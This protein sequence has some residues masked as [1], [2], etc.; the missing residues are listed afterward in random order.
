MARGR[1]K[2]SKLVEGKIIEA[3]NDILPNTIT[4]GLGEGLQIDEE[5]SEGFSQVNPEEVKSIESVSDF[6]GIDWDFTIYDQIE[7]FQSDKSYELT[8]YRPIDETHGLDFNPSWFTEVRDIKES[9]GYYTQYRPGTKA[10]RDFWS[11]QYRRCRDGYESHGY[12]IT[13]DNYFFLNFYR[14]KD[15]TNV[16]VASSGR[17]TSFPQFFSK[18]Y[19]YFHYI[20]LCTHTKHDVCALKAR[21][22]G[23]S[24]IAASLAV[25]MYT[26]VREAHVICTAYSTDKL[27]PLLRKCW[28][29]LEY[30]NVD[31]EDGMRHVRQ[32]YNNDMHK[33]ASKLNK[34]REEY[35]WKSD[36]LGIVADNPN[37]LRGERVDLLLFEEAGSNPVLLKTYIQSNA[38]VEI[39]G[40]KF[41]TR[42]IWG[43]GGDAGA[44]LAGLSKVFYNPKGYNVLPFKHNYSKTG[45][46][47]ETSYFIPAFTFVAGEGYID[48]R[49]VTDTKKAKEYYNNKKNALAENPKEYI[50]FCAEYCFTPEDALALEG[51]NLFNREILANQKAQIELHKAGPRPVRGYLEYKFKN[52]EHTEEAKDG[53]KFIPNNNSK[54]QILEHPIRSDNNEAI[55]NLYVAGIDGIDLGAKETSEATKDPSDFCIIIFRRMKGE[56]PP[57]PVAFYKDRPGDVREAYRIALKLLEYYNCKALLEFSKIGFKNFLVDKRI[58]YKWLMRRTKATLDSPDAVSRQYGVPANEKVI[59]HQLELLAS[60]IQ[61]FGDNIWFI[62][63]INELL[64]YS[65][66]NKRKFD[67][68]AAM[69]MC[70]LADEELIG[71]IPR[72]DEIVSAKWR[73]VGWYVDEKGYKR[74]GI[75]QHQQIETKVNMN[76]Y[77]QSR[78]RSSRPIYY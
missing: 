58:E 65:Y 2:G 59:Q 67:A 47:V 53:F 27:T 68:V 51:D 3:V 9:T 64:E 44:A 5:A 36:I 11:E 55:R 43:T 77:D 8:K 63:I 61:D 33:K 49:G 32:K 12:R 35:G 1:K 29:Q 37:K 57:M 17:Q 14:L 46:L 26:V 7:Y 60:Y 21:G 56:S 42:L 52:N 6:S 39:L 16:K 22:V 45:E 50:M 76:F 30:L 4:V 19:E 70:M 20:D 62:E 13:G 41:G 23:F 31:T 69:G 18:Q 38:L 40:N 48:K 75:I 34:Q 54:L 71:V 72:V 28:E 74:F 78:V 24:E 73:D 66:E 10:H 15:V 25:R